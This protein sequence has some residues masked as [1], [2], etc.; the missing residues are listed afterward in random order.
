M[1][2][3]ANSLVRDLLSLPLYMSQTLIRSTHE[4]RPTPPEPEVRLEHFDL[5]PCC[6]L[7]QPDV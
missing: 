2:A 3:Y 5:Y 1:S 4:S 7:M 6:E